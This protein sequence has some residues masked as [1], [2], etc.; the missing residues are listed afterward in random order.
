MSANGDDVDRTDCEGSSP[1]SFLAS[2]EVS[3]ALLEM[4]DPCEARKARPGQGDVP[5]LPKRAQIS[6]T[7]GS[8]ETV[9]DR[10][11][12]VLGLL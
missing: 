9:S 11:V 2:D 3:S 10:L 7:H 8:G 1:F 6:R 5:K 4:A 12:G